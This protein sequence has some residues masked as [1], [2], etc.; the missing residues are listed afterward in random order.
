MSTK[1]LKYYAVAVIITEREAVVDGDT[2]ATIPMCW[3]DGMVGVFPVFS[4]KEDAV[5]YA[6]DRFHVIEFERPVEE[7]DDK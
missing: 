3:S 1:M 5:R 6:G 7:L 2:T 4:S